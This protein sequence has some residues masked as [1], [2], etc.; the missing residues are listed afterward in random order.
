MS[1]R[2][3]DHIG[4]V[5][6]ITPA[7]DEIASYNRSKAK[8][9][10][11][12]SLGDVPDV[13]GNSSVMKPLVAAVVLMLVVTLGLSAYLY[14]QLTETQS[15]IRLYEV[16]IGDLEQRL[17]VT[18]E[19]MSESSVA[20]KVKVKEMDSEIRKLWDNVWK[21]SKESFA[22]I[23]VTL[24]NHQ[25]S[26]ASSDAYIAS[27]KQLQSKNDRVVADLTQQL[28]SIKSMQSTVTN[29]QKLLASQE[30]SIETTNDKVNR[31]TNSVTALDRRVK[32]TEEWVESINGFRRQ[33]NRD[34]NE[35][36]QKIGQ[37]HPAP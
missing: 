9:A 12:A 16:R 35:L 13:Q 37:M 14:K 3:D 23:D 15:M 2:D 20:M 27:A 32:E 17:S 30:R 21:K 31:M 24:K 10:F 22:K 18:D 26:I 5:P 6:K 11:A 34:I 1:R 36:N 28:T 8:G 33:A 7:H 19:S 25:Q 4:H 29:N